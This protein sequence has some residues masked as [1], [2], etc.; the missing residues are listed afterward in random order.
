M[1]PNY[2]LIYNPLCN[3]PQETYSWGTSSIT[4]CTRKNLACPRV[5]SWPFSSVFEV[6]LKDGGLIN[7]H[8]SNIK[9]G[10]ISWVNLKYI[11]TSNVESKWWIV[12]AMFMDV[13]CTQLQLLHLP[14]G[15]DASVGKGRGADKVRCRGLRISPIRLFQAERLRSRWWWWWWLWW[16]LLFHFC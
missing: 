5:C 4:A 2:N 3:Q 8:K 7:Q 16:L 15:A 1:P 14:Q 6:L 9:H 11:L 13:S 10:D 12:M